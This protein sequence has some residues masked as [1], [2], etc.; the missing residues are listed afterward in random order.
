MSNLWKIY[1]LA[2]TN[3]NF[4][5]DVNALGGLIRPRKFDDASYQQSLVGVDALLLRWFCPL[6]HLDAQLF[7]DMICCES[8]W[9][10]F[11]ELQAACG[12]DTT[13]LDPGDPLEQQLWQVFGLACIDPWKNVDGNTPIVGFRQEL[14]TDLDASDRYGF[15]LTGQ[16]KEKIF[17][18]V[19]KIGALNA[20]QGVAM[21]WDPASL[22]MRTRRPLYQRLQPIQIP[23]GWL[24]FT[25]P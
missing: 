20:L 11:A 15:K 14:Q 23:P 12:L 25:K 16:Q 3:K 17:Q 13:Q 19:N 18:A 1:G 10:R 6:G 9:A 5:N 22:G 8:L 2:G 24:D 21:M 7:Y 4:L